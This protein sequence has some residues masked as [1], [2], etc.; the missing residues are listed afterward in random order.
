M[1]YLYNRLLGNKTRTTD[2]CHG[3]HKFLKYY[4]KWKK[5][6]AMSTIVKCIETLISDGQ[7][8]GLPKGKMDVTTNGYRIYFWKTNYILKGA[9]LCKY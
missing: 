1:V 9:Q 8:L 3:I 7:G 4:A 6:V 2:T 5:Q